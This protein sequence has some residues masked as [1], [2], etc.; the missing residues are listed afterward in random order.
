MTQPILELQHV[1]RNFRVGRQHIIKVLQDVSLEVLPGEIICLVGKALGKRLRQNCRPV[2]RPGDAYEGQS[3]SK[4][5]ERISKASVPS[6]SSTRTPM[7]LNHSY[8]LQYLSF[9]LF[10]MG[11]RRAAARLASR[12]SLKTV[13]LTSVQDVIDNIPTSLAEP[14]PAGEHARC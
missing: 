6:R 5:K 7:S 1:D 13:D 2:V 4:L 3:V 10:R 8:C 11:W 12:S 9:P 14:A